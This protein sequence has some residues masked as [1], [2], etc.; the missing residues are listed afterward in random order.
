MVQL[1]YLRLHIGSETFLSSDTTD[2]KDGL[3]LK[4]EIAGPTFSSFNAM[5]AKTNKKA[6][7]HSLLEI[8]PKTCFEAS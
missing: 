7:T 2:G 5:P 4:L 8:L 1:C 6:L 3:G